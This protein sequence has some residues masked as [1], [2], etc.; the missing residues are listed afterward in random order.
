MSK[1]YLKD[2]PTIEDFQNYVRDMRIERG[3]DNETLIEECLLLGE[4]MGELFK[5]I[6]KHKTTI[7]C[8]NKN[9]KITQIEEEIADL[10][11]MLLCVSNSV[12]IDVEQAFR[13]KEKI[14]KKRK[15][16]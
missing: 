13:N 6:R 2:K 11:I 3:F 14:N 7:A 1:L 4:E 10:F 9:S 15:W 12:G 5:A 8:D 16:S